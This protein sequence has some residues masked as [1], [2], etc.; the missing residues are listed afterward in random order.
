MLGTLPPLRGLSSYCFE[1]ARAVSDRCDIDFLSFKHL[2]PSFLY[3]GG[4]LEEDST[5]P[6]IQ[7]NK[8]TV[9]A[10]LTWYNPISWIAAGL[11]AHTNILHAQWW[12]LPL[13]PVY[14]VICFFYKLRKKPIVITVHN[15]LPHENC[16]F[17]RPL[18]RILFKLCDHFI[19]HTVSN[20]EQLNDHYKIPHNKITKIPHGTL[21]FHKKKNVNSAHIRNKMG[22]KK[23]HKIILFFGSIRPYKGLDTLLTAF[24][25]I[26][27]KI[28]EARL[29][30]AGKLWQKS[31]PYTSLALSL[32]INDYIRTFF[33]YIPSGDVWK[34]FTAAD[35]VVLPYHRFDSQSGVGTTA[36][37]FRKPIIV[38]R[39][40][41]LPDL[42]SDNRYILPP[43]NPEVLADTSG[44]LFHHPER[45]EAR[46][47]SSHTIAKTLSWSTIAKKTCEVYHR[48]LS[49]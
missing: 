1:L 42:V 26:V 49:A 5:F 28:P 8:I 31:N 19:V 10:S 17:Y 44:D 43:G 7:S 4:D 25:E 14:L 9:K 39:V 35:L 21:D 11:F 3:P 38:T 15:V 36:I 27:R 23:D 13:W 34:F 41:G 46:A 47:L 45:L 30:I 12:S 24:A 22:F 18:T 40:G 2:Y 6:P 32:E 48:L 33:D 20:A 29:L 16:L 37:A